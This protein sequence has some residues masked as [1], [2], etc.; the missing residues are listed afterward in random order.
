MVGLYKKKLFQPFS[1]LDGP[2]AT[3]IDHFTTDPAPIELLIVD[4]GFNTLTL[5][6]LSVFIDLPV[7]FFRGETII[8]GQPAIQ[9][10]VHGF[11]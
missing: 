9:C 7:F 5:N 10:L 6:M 1:L 2:G 3:D 11:Y 8:L 4:L